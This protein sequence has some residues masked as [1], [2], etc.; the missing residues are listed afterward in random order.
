VRR[1][2]PELHGLESQWMASLTEAEKQQLK[3]LAE[4]LIASTP[5]IH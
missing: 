1:M 3:A 4:R 2:Q 5:Q